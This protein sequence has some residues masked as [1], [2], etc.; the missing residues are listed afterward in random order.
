MKRFYFKEYEN[1]INYGTIVMVPSSSPKE[2]LNS[3]RN[4]KDGY[5]Y[6]LFKVEEYEE[7]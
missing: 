4:E 5:T 6:E 7:D 1:G 2:A 3:L